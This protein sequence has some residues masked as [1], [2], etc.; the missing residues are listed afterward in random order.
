MPDRDHPLKPDSYR[1]RLL[2]H[3]ISQLL[4]ISTSIDLRGARG[5]GKTWCALA[6]AKSI[7]S[8]DDETI[9]MPLIQMDARIALTGPRPHA[10]DEWAAFPDLMRQAAKASKTPGS[11]LLLT[12]CEP[13]READVRGAKPAGVAGA[14]RTRLRM[15]TLALAERGLSSRAVS[16]GDL[17]SSGGTWPPLASREKAAR[18]SGQ[19]AGDVAPV[20][21]SGQAGEA[22]TN[23]H[24]RAGLGSLGLYA[25]EGGWAAAAARSHEDALVI[26]RNQ[27]DSLLAGD[28]R[29]Q[30]RKES[31]ARA[32]LACVELATGGDTSYAS[33][34]ERAAEAGLD[35]PSRNTLGS[36][37]RTF[38]QLYLLERL[39][40][41]AAPVRSAS[42]VKTKPRLVVADPSLG[43][44]AAGLGPRDLAQN[45]AWLGAAFRALALHDLLAYAEALPSE[46]DARVCY[47]ADAD[48]L[49]VDAVLLLGGDGWAPV[50]LAM[51]EGDAPAA[52]RRLARLERK[53]A[54]GGSTLGGPA[55]KLVVTPGGTPWR[56][57]RTGTVVAPVTSL[58]A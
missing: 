25:C 55:F 11:F 18:A 46:L 40:G 21:A 35:F 6:H 27:V 23:D 4:G 5:A 15:R 45:A 47:Y 50:C 52:I 58:T 56:D 14:A 12:S 43:V 33:L 29:R 7:V 36:Y 8:A 39:P 30:G 53:V 49:S 16:L 17:V 31:V 41:W 3:K 57:E 22:P 38:E 48:G 44:M 9:A 28:V 19:L 2:D 13:T 42:R 20:G 54:A 51:R 32:I 37:A 26:A 1:E 34:A 10:V 24:A